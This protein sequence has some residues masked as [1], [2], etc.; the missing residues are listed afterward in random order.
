MGLPL[1]QVALSY[2]VDDLH[3]TIQQEKI[4]HMAGSQTPQGQQVAALERAIREAGRVPV[5]RNTYYEPLRPTPD[6]QPLPD[7]PERMKTLV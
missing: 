7:M 3:G 1:A 6:M 5:Q 4:F 2:G